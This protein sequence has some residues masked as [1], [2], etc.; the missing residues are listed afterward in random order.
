[1][2]APAARPLAS[3]IRHALAFVAIVWA[4]A[5][6]FV[7]F[8][9]VALGSFDLASSFP[10]LFG[11]VGLP[12]AV[13]LST[14]CTAPG[15]DGSGEPRPA[16]AVLRAANLGAWQLGVIL[17][18]DAMFRQYAA[19]GSPLLEQSAAGL[20]DLAGRLGVQAPSRFRPVQLANA[21]TEFVVF[22]ENS[23]LE[24]ARQLARSFSPQTCELFKLAAFWGYSEI[25]RPSLPGERAV[26]AVEI[27]YH[28]QRA[29]VPEPLW[30][31]MM[32]RLPA[33]ARSD[34]V[35]AQMS[36]LTNGVTNYLS[37]H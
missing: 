9:I 21:N 17:G 37:A 28:A 16:A 36:A 19:A 32:Q 25:V 30:D 7:A 3:R 2:A 10:N 15:V 35:L 27:K 24:T 18:R 20:R 26:F 23:E 22:V 13:A 11:D 1:M 14:S 6:T 5:A 31:P 8:E 33:N 4:I 12:R 29:E 34:E